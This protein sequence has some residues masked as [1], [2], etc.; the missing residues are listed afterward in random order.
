MHKIS[1]GSIKEAEIFTH[2]MYL[3]MTR[4]QLR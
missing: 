3:Q 1:F 2:E 4:S